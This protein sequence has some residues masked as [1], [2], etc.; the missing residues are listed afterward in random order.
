M[1]HYLSMWAEQWQAHSMLKFKHAFTI[2]KIMETQI[3][4]FPLLICY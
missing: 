4:I 1:L 3:F 2:L